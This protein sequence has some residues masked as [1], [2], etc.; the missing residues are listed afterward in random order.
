[1]LVSTCFA[2]SDVSVLS[3]LSSMLE[4]FSSRPTQTKDEIQ[5]LQKD[6]RE[7]ETDLHAKQGF[8]KL[9]H[10]RLENRTKRPGVDLCWDEVA[11]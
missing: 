7:L 11:C 6:I 2:V 3:V 1:M 4:A 10:T 5:D 9:S 8:L